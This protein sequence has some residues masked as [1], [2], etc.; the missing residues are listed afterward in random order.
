MNERFYKQFAKV[1]FAELHKELLDSATDYKLQVDKA[2]NGLR[3]ELYFP[4]PVKAEKMFEIEDIIASSLR[5]NYCI[6]LPVY[7][8]GTF[9]TDYMPELVKMYARMENIALGRG[10][11]DKYTYSY[12]RE[13]AKV[14]IKLRSGMSALLM[15]AADA[16]KF[17]SGCVKSQF[18]Q[19]IDFVFEE[20]AYDDSAR[21]AEWEEL[22]KR[23]NT[24]YAEYEKNRKPKEIETKDSFFKTI[25]D[26]EDK[27]EIGGTMLGNMHFDL[28]E[29]T[30][31]F[32]EVIRKE[33]FPIR[34]IKVEPEVNSEGRV[35]SKKIPVC[36]CGELFQIEDKES[37]D[38]TKINYKAYMTDGEASVMFRFSVGKDEADFAPPKPGTA[39][40]LEGKAGYDDFEKETVVRAEKINKVKRLRRKDKYP[41]KRTELHLHTNMS[42]NDALSDPEAVMATASA[43]GWNAVAITDH[44]NVQAFPAIMKARKKYPDVK[45]IYGMEGYLVD[46]TARA[47]FGVKSGTDYSFDESEFIIFDIETTGLSPVDCAITEIGASLYKGG[48]VLATFGTYVDPEMPIPENITRLTGI[49]AETVKGAPKVKEAVQKFLEFAGDRMLVAHNANFDIGFIRKAC[50]KHKIKFNNP[51]LDTLPL[52]RYI[53]SELNKHTLDSIGNY[54]NLG[55]FNHHRAT[56][57]TA[58]LAA[59]FS[60]MA[61]KLRRQGVR[62]IEEMNM[63][64]AASSD[65]KKLRSYHVTILV[66]NT[67]GL[68]NLYQLISQSYLDFYHRNPRI[69]KTL[70]A[71]HREGLIIGSAC[72]AG[73]LFRG[74]LDGK[75]NSDLL[76]IADFYDYFEI[77]PKDNNSFLIEEGT[78]S[79]YGRLE[80]INKQIIRIAD[81]QKKPVCATGDAHFIEPDDEIYRQIMQVGLKYKDAMHESKLYLRTTEEMLEEFSYLGDRAEEIV[82]DNPQKIADMIDGTVKPIPDGTYTPEIEGAEEELI[83]SCKE[84]A[85]EWYG[86]EG[87]VPE[88][89]SARLDRELGSIIK[90]GFAVL[91][92][93]ARKLV[94]NSERTGYLVGSRGSVGSS[95]VATFSGVSEVNP[96]PPHYR[97]PNCRYSEWFT[98][99]SVGSGFD[100]PDKPCPK[101]G[102]NMITDGHDIPFETFLGFHGEKA[103][104][105]DLNFS[106]DNQSEAHR[107][108]E[109][110][111]GKENIFRAGTVGTIAS[112]TAYGYVKKF[113]EEQGKQLSKAE[114]NRLVNGL[115]G[116]KRTTGQHPGGIVVIPKQYE[117]YDFTPVQ[118]PA[119]KDDS[120]VITTHFA[121]EFLHDTLLKLDIL[122]HDVPTIYKWLETFTGKD[123]RTVPMNDPETMELFESTRPL[124]VSPEQIGSDFGTFGLPE[125]GT[126]YVRE[127]IR[128]AHPTKFS[129]LL[130]LSGLS[131][132]T[133]IWLGNGQELIKNGTCTISEIIGTRD[134]IMVYLMYAGVEKESAFKIMEFVRKNKKGLPIPEAMVETMR[135]AG[136]PEW[137]IESLAKIR[138]MFPKAHAAAYM[139]SAIRLGWYKVHEPLAFYATYFT[140][141][142]SKNAGFDSELAL[143]STSVISKRIE[144]LEA[145]NDTTAKDEDTITVM[146]MVREMYA[147]GITFLPVDVYKSEA[148]VFKPE[149]GK[150]RLPLSALNGL[151][152]TAAENIYKA[153]HET[154]C[155]TL[156]E[157][158]I[159][160]GLNKNVVE[161]LKSNNCLG[162]MP[163]TDQLSL[164]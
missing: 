9:A 88:I 34:E 156:E 66:K 65:P 37:R 70:L 131:H 87:E 80:E 14:T 115:V 84:T 20:T 10:G 48:E 19:N 105:I 145:L 54:Y 71:A 5:L 134:S 113:L 1:A 104:D 149:D 72:E 142:C 25:E 29:R 117:I 13:S 124:G 11:L 151:G 95:V 8:A 163:E 40:L 130:Q 155:A 110:L 159:T 157:L 103:P 24:D 121:F 123:V 31:V 57:D 6:V 64:M 116:V 43:W 52:S 128:D 36:I 56:D 162:S 125:C 30:P 96:L 122:G 120:G 51:Y 53:N 119:D 129:D 153:I 33:P 85:M 32:K 38:G 81:K 126:P 98:D 138:Y 16:G 59:I 146:Q 55:E 158:R 77:M 143:S 164:F 82:I 46:D 150:I 132:G 23:A 61:D 118:H 141:K 112:K 44:G 97:C 2:G 18:E 22:Q 140:V 109:V 127:M 89:V 137:Y 147:R 75:A 39:I 139:I 94:L 160:A 47:V 106:S 83:N 99:G 92:V 100:L 17:F 73:E 3:L 91:Y 21:A 58:M 90:N 27:Y 107:Y 28:S 152:D 136:V 69:P 144:E 102:E 154:D 60:C 133:G 15:D 93:I 148:Y 108:T 41:R 78:L 35:F 26:K 50:E 86:Y 45:P 79:D 114:E 135:A 63:A 62:N 12:D 4:I 74:I 111:F 67:V 7:P 42:A 76:R 49:S 161:I 101:C 68:R